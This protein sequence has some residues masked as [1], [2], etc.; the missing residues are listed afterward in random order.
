MAD[1][2][3]INRITNNQKDY[4]DLICPICASLMANCILF[5]CGHEICEQCMLQ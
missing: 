2:I 1:Q 3:D 4:E 5:K